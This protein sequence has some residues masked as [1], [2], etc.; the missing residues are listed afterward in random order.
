MPTDRSTPHA[1]RLRLV[2]STDIA[3]LSRLY[4]EL[5]EDESFDG[6]RT[7]DELRDGMA[8]H[9]G[10]GEVAFLFMAEDRV[11][12]YALIVVTKSLPYIH[13]FYICRDAR[14]HGFGKEAFYVLLDTL[15]TDRIDLDVF[16][17]NERGRAFWS[18]LGF[19]PRSIIM[20]YQADH[21]HG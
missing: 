14:R 19:V 6:L 18:S 9:L 8:S 12:G 17:W 5:L 7:L 10:A 21:D 2:P 20:R 16:V 1:R 4:Q 13:H 15:K 11:V 3:L